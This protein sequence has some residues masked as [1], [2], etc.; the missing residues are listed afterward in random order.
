MTPEVLAT[1]FVL[2]FPKVWMEYLLIW[3]TPGYELASMNTVGFI[4]LFPEDLQRKMRKAV[5]VA[6]I[7]TG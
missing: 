3:A 6:Q 1:L 5:L 7:E 2:S 4:N